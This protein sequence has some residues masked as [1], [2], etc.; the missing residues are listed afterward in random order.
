MHWLYHVTSPVKSTSTRGIWA[1]EGE[2]SCTELLGFLRM[3][4]DFEARTSEEVDEKVERRDL[5]F[6]LAASSKPNIRAFS[7][8]QSAQPACRIHILHFLA[9]WRR[10][11]SNWETEQGLK[12]FAPFEEGD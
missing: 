3:R 5:R 1:V 8:S 4:A 2:R 10:S 11:A 7:L 6:Q 9:L 12:A